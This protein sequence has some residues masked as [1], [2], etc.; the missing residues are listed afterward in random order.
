MK[1]FLIAKATVYAGSKATPTVANSATTPDLL[2]NGAVGIY[3]TDLSTGTGKPI[4]LTAAATGNIT[5]NRIIFAQGTASGVYVCKSV[6]AIDAISAYYAEY[7]A[8]TKQV[9]FLGFNGTSG[10]LNLNLATLVDYTD[11]GVEQ[12]SRLG[13][14]NPE[15]DYTSSNATLM[16]VDTAYTAAG[17]VSTA[18][19]NDKKTISYVIANV[20]VGAVTATAASGVTFLNGS[21]AVSGVTAGL[22]TGNYLTITIDP[23][24]GL[25][26]PI[27][28]ANSISVL[29][30]MTVV[31]SAVT[32]DRPF[33]GASQTVTAAAFNAATTS[34]GTAPTSV[35]IAFTGYVSAYQQFT[36]LGEGAFINATRTAPSDGAPAVGMFPGAGT[37][38]QVQGLE[39][40]FFQNA[41][42]WDTADKYIR[43]PVSQVDTTKI[44]DVYFLKFANVF[45]SY[46]PQEARLTEEYEIRLAVVGGSGNPAGN[47]TID[48]VIRSLFSTTTTA[49]AQGQII[50]EGPLNPAA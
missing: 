33:E 16:A 39:N 14:P 42:F 4:L 38:D 25:I 48:A 5:Q 29:Y 15:D 23:Q 43:G 30:K 46:A 11:A 13:R 10:S 31:G 7:A 49:V 50:G 20:Q 24:T 44:Y 26:V 45:N 19:N 21:A 37:V 8:T 36:V 40:T 35:G 22:T 3:Y 34:S 47:A 2:A 27:A 41:G 17:K 9:S 32:L 28:T 6:K 12:I 18:V 1:E